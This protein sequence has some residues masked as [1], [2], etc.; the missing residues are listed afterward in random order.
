MS[1]YLKMTIVLKLKINFL[2]RSLSPGIYKRR[3][4]IRIGCSDVQ[5]PHHPR[6]ETESSDNIVM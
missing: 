5:K 1:N 3:I 4:N 2:G 6:S